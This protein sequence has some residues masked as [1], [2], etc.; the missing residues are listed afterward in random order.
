MKLY[1]PTIQVAQRLALDPSLIEGM[2][3]A[4]GALPPHALL[5]RAATAGASRWIM[6]YLFLDDKAG[7]VVGAGGFKDEPTEGKL[8]I[9]FNVAPAYQG[10]GFATQGVRLICDDALADGYVL[11]IVAETL[12]TNVASQRVLEKS[13]FKNFDLR[14]APE[15]TFKRWRRLKDPLNAAHPKL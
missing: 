11:L 12:T 7:R 4:P 1:R 15:G 8:E 6:P 10:Q 9:G 2:E 5:A 14:K 13:G 3:I